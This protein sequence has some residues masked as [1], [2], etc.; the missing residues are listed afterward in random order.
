[1]VVQA[2]KD[3]YIPRTKYIRVSSIECNLAALC[4]QYLTFDCFDN[5]VTPERLREFARCG[6][7]SLQDYAVAKWSDHVHAIVKM[8][9]DS[10][11]ADDESFTALKTIGIAL[12][13]FS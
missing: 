12:E 7:F 10:F 1:M 8:S 13:E 2:N 11:F 3:R 4:L 5:Q 9:P 6:Y